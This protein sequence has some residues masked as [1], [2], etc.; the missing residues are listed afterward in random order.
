MESIETTLSEF[1]QALL[2]QQDSSQLLK[3]SLNT[4]NTNSDQMRRL[5]ERV[6]KN[7]QNENSALED[8]LRLME[9]SD[10]QIMKIVGV[11]REQSRY[12]ES[13]WRRLEE[14]GQGVERI[15]ERLDGV[16]RREREGHKRVQE[17]LERMERQMQA[18]DEQDKKRAEVMAALMERLIGGGGTGRQDQKPKSE[19]HKGREEKDKAEHTR[20]EQK[21]PTVGEIQASQ[22]EDR[23]QTKNN[24]ISVEEP[25]DDESMTQPSLSDHQNPFKND[26]PRPNRQDPH[27]REPRDE[28]LEKQNSRGFS[29]RR[30]ETPDR[31]ESSLSKTREFQEF[32]RFK[33]TRY[34]RR[35][36]EQATREQS[37]RDRMRYSLEHADRI[38]H[39]NHQM[40]REIEE[41]EERKRARELSQRIE[42]N[43][44]SGNENYYYD[45]PQTNNFEDVYGRE[46]E[47]QNNG[48]LDR[49]RQDQ[50]AQNSRHRRGPG[51][52]LR[53]GEKRDLGQYGSGRRDLG[54]EYANSQISDQRDVF[55]PHERESAR[56]GGGGGI[57]KR[58]VQS[59]QNPVCSK[60]E[61][62]KKIRQETMARASLQRRREE[63]QKRD[64]MREMVK[65]YRG[66]NQKA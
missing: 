52:H 50:G 27:F 45:Y 42:N 65:K 6:V 21:K 47:M 37:T 11:M 19:S 41:I 62:E 25:N 18:R 28:Q 35:A 8:L 22:N 24:A 29:F 15:G 5:L 1:Q 64:E 16:E 38:M 56:N 23:H 59:H 17:T 46:R 48:C 36:Q 34:A 2:T 54:P 9:T 14:V 20:Q 61:N 66:L 63:E 10:T 53:M 13:N 26:I 40:R 7:T 3:L 33:R 55:H 51:N 43:T 58:N 49:R 31:F 32:Q 39:E 30:N 57:D 12:E 60:F 44:Y 4:I